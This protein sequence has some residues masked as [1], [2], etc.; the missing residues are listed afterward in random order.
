VF[1]YA[2]A[3]KASQVMS[4]SLNVPASQASLDIFGLATGS[5]LSSG[6]KVNTWTGTLPSTQD[7]IIEV[8]PGGGQVVNYSLTVTVN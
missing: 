1:T 3:C 5:L 4:V 6:S 7:Y 2:I 8:I